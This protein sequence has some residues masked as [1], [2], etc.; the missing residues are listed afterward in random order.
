MAMAC[1]GL[2]TFFPDPPDLRVPLLN[3]LITFPTFLSFL[4]KLNDIIQTDPSF[5]TLQPERLQIL[6]VV[7]NAQYLVVVFQLQLQTE[8]RT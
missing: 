6:Q 3:S 5:Q 4:D 2:V 7:G 1:L 8:V